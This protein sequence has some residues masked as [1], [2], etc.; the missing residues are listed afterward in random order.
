MSHA[1]GWFFHFVP[2]YNSRFSNYHLLFSLLFLGLSVSCDRM[3]FS[4]C[5][6]LQSRILEL[7]LRTAN[8]ALQ[9]LPGRLASVL[10]PQPTPNQCFLQSY[11][12]P[13]IPR[14]HQ[15]TT[16][17]I[18]LYFLIL[19][20]GLNVSCDRMIFSIWPAYNP[21]FSNYYLN[22]QPSHTSPTW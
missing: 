13:H 19:F 8:P 18:R 2:V 10:R 11:D 15:L 4:I 6:S 1:I 5:T 3:I 14:Q 20:Q 22:R 16:V 21:R 9:A 17:V 7:P 12:T